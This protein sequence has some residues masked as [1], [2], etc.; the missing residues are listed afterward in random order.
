[1]VIQHQYQKCLDFAMQ[2][3]GIS[4]TEDYV[5]QSGRHDSVPPH[6]QLFALLRLTDKDGRLAGRMPAAAGPG[7]QN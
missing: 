7:L 4:I 2:E 6:T 1:M 3:C 5:A